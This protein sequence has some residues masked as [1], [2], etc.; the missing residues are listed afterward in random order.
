MF[1]FFFFFFFFGVA[2]HRIQLL[3]I[4]VYAF[5]PCPSVPHLHVFCRTH[6]PARIYLTHSMEFSVFGVVVMKAASA[7]N[8]VVQL[9]VN[10]KVKINGKTI[11]F[12]TDV[13][14]HFSPS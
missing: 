9:A 2:L 7:L 5:S 6:S 4:H 8:S 13:S 11:Y 1:S 10:I 14:S 12:L 3:F